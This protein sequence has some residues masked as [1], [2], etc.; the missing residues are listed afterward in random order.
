MNRMQGIE[1][2]EFR[3][4]EEKCER[5]NDVLMVV[6]R[7][8]KPRN[9]LEVPQLYHDLLRP[10]IK[11]S[12]LVSSDENIGLNMSIMNYWALQARLIVHYHSG[13]TDCLIYRHYATSTEYVHNLRKYYNTHKL[14][15]Y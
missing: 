4:G 11:I 8:P 5:I 12:S 13:H 15:G 6:C 10:V 3:G 7:S 9:F 14:H 1:G 2:G